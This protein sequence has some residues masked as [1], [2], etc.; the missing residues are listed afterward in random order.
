MCN[1]QWPK[2]VIYSVALFRPGDRHATPRSAC[3]LGESTRA[4]QLIEENM[5]LIANFKAA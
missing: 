2:V 1:I 3:A 5:G 4:H